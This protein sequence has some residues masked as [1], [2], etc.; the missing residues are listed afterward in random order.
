MEFTVEPLHAK[1]LK[2]PFTA[3]APNYRKRTLEVGNTLMRKRKG[4]PNEPR[5]KWAVVRDIIEA[6]PA[7]DTSVYMAVLCEG[8]GEHARQW[9]IWRTYF[10]NNRHGRLHF[11]QFGPQ[12]PLAVDEWIQKQILERAWYEKVSVSSSAVVGA[13]RLGKKTILASLDKDRPGSSNAD[14]LGA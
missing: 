12:A 6:K 8:V 4:Y 7:D 14:I 5:Y 3:H 13:D 2:I 9:Y 11:G 10:T 1:K